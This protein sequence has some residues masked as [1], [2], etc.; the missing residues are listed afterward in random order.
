MQDSSSFWRDIPK[1]SSYKLTLGKAKNLE[2]LKN[3]FH[4]HG[5]SINMGKIA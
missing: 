5:Q 2:F 1:S 4:G 3:N